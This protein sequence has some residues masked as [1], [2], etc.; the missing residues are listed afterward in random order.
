M[1]P[2]ATGNGNKTRQ[3]SCIIQVDGKRM[4]ENVFLDFFVLYNR[5]CPTESTLKTNLST[6]RAAIELYYAQ[7]NSVYP[8]ARDEK[9]KIP[10][11]QAQ[12]KKGFIQQLTRY[13]D[14]DGDASTTK[15]ETHK[16]GPYLKS[17]SL[18]INP[19]NGLNDESLIY[20][21]L[22]LPKEHLT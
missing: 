15:D 6:M 13:S 10:N 3:V 11:N 2:F 7:H 1:H 14:Q 12:A 21:R 22:I 4:T 5:R 9:V 19:Y 17:D 8:G 18:P 16:F 20:T